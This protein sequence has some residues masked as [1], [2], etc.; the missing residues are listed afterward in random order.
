M[1]YPPLAPNAWLRYDVVRRLLPPD[2]SSVL[3]IGCGQGGFAARLAQSAD[4]L[5][6]EPDATSYEKARSRLVAA[7]GRGEVR[8]VE[9]GALAVDRQFDLVCAFEVLEHLE[10]D[11]RAVAEWVGYVRPGGWL[12]LST[13]AFQSRYG[14]YDRH[15]G[16]FRRYDP[17]QMSALLTRAGLVEVQ[18][19]L[20]AA[21][22]GYLLERTKNAMIARREPR[23]AEVSMAE[24]TRRS[25]RWLQPD[26][27]PVGVA[28]QVGTMPFRRLQR[29]FS[30]RGTGL[31]A[32]A[33]RPA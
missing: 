25:G 4:Y 1:R 12:L 9:L 27:A 24:R 16:H 7:G 20:Y 3:E 10:D 29:F 33:R 13:P 17:E 11:E 2:V 18:T 22:L 30:G 23:S 19:V 8:N 31:V 28:L 5:G 21:P 32:R 14:P 6:V 15:A 26:S